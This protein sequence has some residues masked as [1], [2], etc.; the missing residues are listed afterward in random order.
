MIVEAESQRVYEVEVCSVAGESSTNGFEE[1]K[2]A[3]F[4]DYI[5]VRDVKYAIVG[6]STESTEEMVQG[7]RFSKS[8]GP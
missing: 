7:E 6:V 1:L 5:A 8:L 3:I 2:D 4:V